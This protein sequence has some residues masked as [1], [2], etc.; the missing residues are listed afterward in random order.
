MKVTIETG[1]FGYIVRDSG[2]GEPVLITDDDEVL[3]AQEL[4]TE[5]NHRLG[6]PGEPDSSRRVLAIILPGIGWEPADGEVCEHPWARRADGPGEPR[7]SCPCG[8]ELVVR[9]ALSTAG[10]VGSKGIF[11]ESRRD[12]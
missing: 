10:A 2:R 7:W 3:A 11:E 6:A 8:T 9:S 4:L 12:A 1:L 5:V